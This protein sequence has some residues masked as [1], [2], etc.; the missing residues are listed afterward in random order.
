MSPER[1][2]AK[3][4]HQPTERVVTV[5]ELLSPA[6]KAPGEDGLEAYW[7]SEPGSS[8]VAAIWLSWICS[9]AA[10]ACRWPAAAAG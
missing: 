7:Q 4:I 10:S 9:A 8:A 1:S 2:G 3:I 5:L 6:N